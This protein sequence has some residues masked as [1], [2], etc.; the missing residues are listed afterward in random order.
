MN[1]RHADDAARELPPQTLLEGWRHDFHRHPEI[2]FEEHRTSGRIAGLLEEMGIEVT[3]G[4]AGTGVVGR[5]RGEGD[6]AGSIAL[7]ADIDALPITEENTFAHASGHAGRMHACGHDGHTTMLL[8]AAWALSR[9]PAFGGEVVFVFQPAEENE[10]GARVMIE[11][12][13][14]ERFP[15]DACYGLHNWPGL[16]VGE[17][18]VHESAVMASFD[19]FTLT[20]RG[21]GCHAGMPHLGSDV[22]LAGSQLV[23]QLQGLVSRE[24]SPTDQAVLSV[25]S[26]R[27]GDTFN[28]M[29][30]S[31]TLLGT[32]RCFD[33]AVRARIESRLRRAVD[34]LAAFHELEAE[35]DYR[36]CYPPTI[37]TP[38]HGE[39]CGAVLDAVLGAGRT[40]RDLPPSMAAEDF[41]FMLEARPGAYVWL[42]N[43]R[44]SRP[45]HHPRYDFDDAALLFGTRYW[46]ALVDS[47]LGGRGA[48]AS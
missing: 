22:V 37:N 11:D 15:V 43:G 1:D 14:F 24:T 16:A 18:A 44:D 5:L 29:P 35:L 20:L 31:A 30:G 12:G 25:T 42:G 32:V 48:A 7:R 28:V 23:T 38:A 27:A 45:L 40:R 41:A 8:G 3:R 6:G 10:G 39:R 19:A 26:F 46:I 36:V 13:L 47:L 17:G 33:E 2:A 4:L 34:S 9:A 21:R